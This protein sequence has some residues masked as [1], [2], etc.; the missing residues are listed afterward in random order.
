MSSHYTINCADNMFDIL[1]NNKIIVSCNT[2]MIT[3]DGCTIKSTNNQILITP[4][5][6]NSSTTINVLING[7]E[8]AMLSR[9]RKN[10]QLTTLSHININTNNYSLISNNKGILISKCICGLPINTIKYILLASITCGVVAGCFL[11]RIIA[12]FYS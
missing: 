12:F 5:P 3:F 10:L 2:D 9:I 11:L 7:H 6:W 4:S 1:Y 8:N